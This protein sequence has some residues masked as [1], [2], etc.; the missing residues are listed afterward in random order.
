MKKITMYMVTHKDVDFVPEGRT[1]IFVGDGENK[2]NYIRDNTGDNIAIKNKYYC[3]LTAMYWIW[4]NDK[5]SDYVSIEHYRRFFMGKNFS[6]IKS[7][8]IDKLLEK[9][10]IITTKRYRFKTSIREY[11]DENIVK[12][13]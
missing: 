13:V 2:S 8:A 11:L 5:K 10:N 3:E 12:F 1:P 4:K 6:T 7:E 9:N